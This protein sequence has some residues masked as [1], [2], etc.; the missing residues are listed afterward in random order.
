MDVGEAQ[1]GTVVGCP[2]C[3]VKIRIP[4]GKTGKMPAVT[5]PAPAPAPQVAPSKPMAAAPSRARRRLGS[6]STTKMR[7]ATRMRGRAGAAGAGGEEDEEGGYGVPEKKKS[8][9]PLIVGIV[10]G[11]VILV[12]VIII[13]V[14]SGP[15]KTANYAQKTV[16]DEPPAAKPASDPNPL[17]P[18]PTP[19][20][21]E[22]PA[23]D[24]TD[25]LRDKI[26]GASGA[27]GREW[28]DK[29]VDGLKMCGIKNQDP[30][31][32]EFENDID[33][34]CKMAFDN[35]KRMGTNAYPYLLV[36]LTDSDPSRASGAGACLF[37]LAN[38]PARR[39]KPGNAAAIQ[40]EL[41]GLLNVSDDAIRK[42]EQDL[43]WTPGGGGN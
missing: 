8:N 39:V 11:A 25:A 3:Q 4:T 13:I 34:T 15:K 23:G 14:A 35:V 42:A 27:K 16:S 5:T 36:Y 41:K 17:P 40:G 30:L 37:T 21:G 29:T 9:T 7:A 19:N 38:K 6:G 12:G 22:N 18:P 10:A 26:R 24:P 43:G 32:W 20:V 33:P 1:P 2:G 28:W 31:F